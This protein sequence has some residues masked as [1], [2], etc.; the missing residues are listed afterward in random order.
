VQQVTDLSN[1][2]FVA[3]GDNGAGRPAALGFVFSR[4][5]TPQAA[6]SALRAAHAA[7]TLRIQPQVRP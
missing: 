1:P 6:E 4:A 7:L 2:F 5:A 3:V